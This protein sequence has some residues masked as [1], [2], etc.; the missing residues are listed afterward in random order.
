MTSDTH[1]EAD[2]G[3]ESVEKRDAEVIDTVGH[4]ENPDAYVVRYDDETVEYEPA[5]PTN[6]VLFEEGLYDEVT[7]HSEFGPVRTYVDLGDDTYRLRISDEEEIEVPDQYRSD[8]IDALASFDP[9][10]ELADLY[11]EIT[12]GAVDQTTVDAFYE[13]FPSDRIERTSLGWIVDDTFLV[14]WDARNE[15]VG[16][17]VHEVSGGGTERV[18]GDQQ[19]VVLDNLDTGRTETVH[20]PD[21]ETHELSPADQQFITTISILLDPEE[22]VG[23]ELTDAIESMKTTD[24]GTFFDERARQATVRDFTDAKSGIHHGHDFEKHSVSDLNVTQEVQDKLWSNPYDHLALHEMK[25]RRDEFENAMVPVFTDAPNDDPS[26]WR[27]IEQ[28]AE[29]A[30]IPEHMK[31]NINDMFGGDG[32]RTLM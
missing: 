16:V 17:E 26:K 14:D 6:K 8:F 30:P 28:T 21:G 12:G 31:H 1:S 29:N 23:V 24:A 4:P 15:L 2:S 18:D 5:T 25:L 3:R 9:A 20:G 11:D 19:A 32:R 22:Y 27:K 10:N 7:G 13:S